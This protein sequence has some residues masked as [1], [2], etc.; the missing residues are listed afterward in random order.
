[1]STVDHYSEHYRSAVQ[2]LVPDELILSVGVFTHARV[3]LPDGSSTPWLA[4]DIALGA[5]TASLVAVHFRPA[6]MEIAPV[7]VLATWSRADVTVA[8]HETTVLRLLHVRDDRPGSE[9]V[10]LHSP[11]QLGAFDRLNDALYRDLGV[12]VRDADISTRRGS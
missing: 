7:A 8:L 11:R 9:L 2:H 6:G 4:D 3:M 12:A 1:M 5:G 10:E